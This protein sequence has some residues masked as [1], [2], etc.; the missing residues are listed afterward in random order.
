MSEWKRA[1]NVC[2]GFVL[3]M[4]GFLMGYFTC[5]SQVDLQ[6][7]PRYMTV[8]VDDDIDI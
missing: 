4:M 6:D 5:F 1:R 7:A 3:I 2:G 8:C